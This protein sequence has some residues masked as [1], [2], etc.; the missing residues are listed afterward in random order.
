MHTFQEI[1]GEYVVGYWLQQQDGTQRWFEIMNWDADV[2]GAESHV[3]FLNGG[4]GKS[5]GE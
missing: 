2:E 5:M 3:N 4:R 1:D